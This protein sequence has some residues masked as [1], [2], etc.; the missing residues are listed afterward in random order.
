MIVELG[1]F[2][3]DFRYF[4][5]F[6]CFLFSLLLLLL[7]MDKMD[8]RGTIAL[9]QSVLYVCTYIHI[10]CRVHVL[11]TVHHPSIHIPLSTSHLPTT[12]C[13]TYMAKGYY[14]VCFCLF[15]SVSVSHSFSLPLCFCFC[16]CFLLRTHHRPLEASSL[17]MFFFYLSTFFCSFFII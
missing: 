9:V 8:Q 2:L 10:T 13:T 6:W 11:H 3:N 15:L 14:R 16:F 17:P 4:R 5:Y 1:D 12:Y 7:L